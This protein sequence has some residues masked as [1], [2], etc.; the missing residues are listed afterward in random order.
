MGVKPLPSRCCVSA[1]NVTRRLN[2]PSSP[3]RT[4]AEITD[5]PHP[6]V[7]GLA[8]S[9]SNRC[10]TW[11]WP[12]RMA[13]IRAVL[14]PGQSEQSFSTVRRIGAVA[15]RRGL[16]AFF[17][18]RSRPAR[19]DGAAPPGEP[20]PPIGQVGGRPMGRTRTLPLPCA[21]A[22][23]QPHVITFTAAC[24]MPVSNPAPE[25]ALQG[26]IDSVSY[27]HEHRSRD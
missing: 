8:P 24:L 20:P 27:R 23:G 13:R 16:R 2:S 3:R 25:S 14:P 18:R 1:P 5:V 26:A 6:L 22:A 11:I 7:F 12:P 19:C 21:I 17:A 9:S 10:A 15:S 4:A